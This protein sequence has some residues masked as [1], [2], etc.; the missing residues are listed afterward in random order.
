[1]SRELQLHHTGTWCAGLLVAGL[2]LPW[3][4]LRAGD[5]SAGAGLWKKLKPFAEPPAE[6]AG[7]FGSYKSP[8]EFADGTLAK[9]PADWAKRRAE[10]LSTWHERL[11][12]WPPLVKNPAVK[13][14]ESVKRDGYT[15]HRVQVQA[16]PAGNWV[17]GYLLI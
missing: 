17:D 12:P 10:I 16:S 11:G 13:K 8:L 1:M 6:F 4:S 15:R 3:T 9:T 14:L 2:L 7:K 5:D